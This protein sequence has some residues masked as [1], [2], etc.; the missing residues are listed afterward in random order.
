MRDRFRTAVPEY[1]SENAGVRPS[2]LAERREWITGLLKELK[3]GEQITVRYWLGQPV[4][5]LA[6]EFNV[7]RSAIYYHIGV[8]SNDPVFL[9]KIASMAFGD[10]FAADTNAG[11][12]EQIQ[13]NKAA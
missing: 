4:T 13:P 10:V 11:S 2:D 3:I 7:T 6:S 8:K 1:L 5:L 12:A 9:Q